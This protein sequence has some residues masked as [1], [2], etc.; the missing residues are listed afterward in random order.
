MRLL[1]LHSR[2][3]RRREFDDEKS[4]CKLNSARFRK[5]GL[6]PP[7][8]FCQDEKLKKCFVA[9]SILFIMMSFVHNSR[10]SLCS[11]SPPPTCSSPLSVSFS[12]GHLQNHR[13]P[14]VHRTISMNEKTKPSSSFSFLLLF[15]SSLLLN[16]LVLPPH[17]L[18]QTP[19]RRQWLL[20]LEQCTVKSCRL[21]TYGARLRLYLSLSADWAEQ[22]AANSNSKC[23][24]EKPWVGRSSVYCTPCRENGEAKFLSTLLYFP[25]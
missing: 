2:R 12:R 4:N 7:K 6:F 9:S 18:L 10:H 17:P 16:S 14:C 11:S 13:D 5:N 22:L 20:R 15:L 23:E 21:L 25:I 1:L 24:F 8:L 3:R 19:A